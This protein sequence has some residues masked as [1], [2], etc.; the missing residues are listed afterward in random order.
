LNVVG[1]WLIEVTTT[2][3]VRAPLASAA[4]TTTLSSVCDTIEAGTPASSTDMMSAPVPRAVPETVTLL[5]AAI[6]PTLGVTDEIT[7]AVSLFSNRDPTRKSER[8]EKETVAG[9][10]HNGAKRGRFQYH[11]GQ[12][13]L[14][15][16]ADSGHLH[17]D[18]YSSKASVL[19]S[20]ISTAAPGRNAPRC[21]TA[22]Q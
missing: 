19:V 10:E 9:T 16:G 20:F 6:G 3:P 13:G 12:T 1:P 22:T 2:S 17:H 18:L 15:G 8:T 5:P 7:A 14:V 21:R 4:V 11:V